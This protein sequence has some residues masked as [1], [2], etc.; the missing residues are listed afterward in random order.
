MPGNPAFAHHFWAGGPASLLGLVFPFLFLGLLFVLLGAARSG[1]RR[2]D[3]V[4]SGRKPPAASSR[5]V[6]KNTHAGQPVLASDLEREETAR[7][8]SHAVGEGRLSLEEGGQRIDAV[9]RSRHRHEL[10]GL[11]ADLPSGVPATTTAR[12][13]TSAPLRLGLLAVAAALVLAAVLVQAVAGL[14]ELW[15]L[16][17]V[18]VGAPALLPRR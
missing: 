15:P 14:W 7:L 6:T 11:V 5:A 12:P 17:V 8:V 13:F 4:L 16:A 1:G 3:A 10:V 18:A 2:A 9:L